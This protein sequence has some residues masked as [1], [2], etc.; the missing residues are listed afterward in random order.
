MKRI[1]W[2]TLLPAL[3][4]GIMVFYFEF[5]IPGFELTLP[6]YTGWIT[7]QPFTNNLTDEPVSILVL[8]TLV[9]ITFSEEKHEDEWISTIRLEPLQWSVYANCILLIL[10]I[11]LIYD[12]YFFQALIY[13][14][15]SILLLFLLRFN[16][17]MRV[18]FNPNRIEVHEK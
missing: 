6:F 12:V 5:E 3:T 4:L 18:K 9:M 7:D 13:N 10:C 1:G 15:Y 17:V 11:L 16:Y 2:F 14:M 8:I